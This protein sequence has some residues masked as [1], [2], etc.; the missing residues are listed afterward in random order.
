[1]HLF[2]VD[3]FNLAFLFNTLSCLALIPSVGVRRSSEDAAADAGLSKGLGE[4]GIV[5]FGSFAVCVL[6]LLNRRP[7]DLSLS[8]S[9]KASGVARSSRSIKSAR[10]IRIERMEIDTVKNFTSESQPLIH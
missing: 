1:V 2:A 7:L 9:V 6:D 3:L 8:S 10:I 4:K 5:S